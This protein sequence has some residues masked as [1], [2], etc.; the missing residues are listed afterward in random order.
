MGIK[1]SLAYVVQVAVG[2]VSV[3]AGSPIVFLGSQEQLSQAW[4]YRVLLGA[5]VVKIQNE[6][7][8]DD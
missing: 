3:K 2:I 1:A 5:P 7:S 6:Y 8:H 4:W